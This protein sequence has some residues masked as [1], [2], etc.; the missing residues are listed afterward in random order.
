MIRGTKVLPALL[1]ASFATWSATPAAR[2]D[3][4]D[5]EVGGFIGLHVFND[6]NELG[7]WDRADADSLRNSFTVGLRLAYALH[8]LVSVEGEAAFYPT[9]SRESDVDA[10]AFGYRI[11]GLVHFTKPE[12]RLRPFAVLGFGGMSTTRSDSNVIHQDTDGMFHGGLGLKYRVG[13]RWGV[14]LDGR[15][16]TPPSTANSGVTVDFEV[17]LGL[18]TTLGKSEKKAEPAPEQPKDSDG[19]GIY[20][21][22]DKCPDQKEDVD[23]YV[24]DDGCPDLDNDGDGIPD[25]KDECPNDAE[26]ANGVDDEDGCPETDEDGDGL[27]GSADECPTEPEDK[28]GFEDGNGCPDPDNDGDGIA[29]ADDQCPA[30]AETANGYQDADGCP[31]EVPATVAKFTGAIKGIKFKTNSA[32]IARTSYKVLSKA[33]KVLAEFPNLRVEIQGHTDDKGKD[34]KNLA[35]SQ[36]RAESVKKY[37]VK[38]GIDE[39]RLEA[40]GYGETAP[41]ADNTT[42]KG[43]AENRRVEFK[44]IGSN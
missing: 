13:D 18:Y 3:G 44:L 12:K 16:L 43:Q 31:D 29:D 19:D 32:V 36:K 39:S 21:D 33:A 10:I 23:Q 34:E 7:V 40:K 41:V 25:E 27:V 9:G 17:L 35:L 6:D 5:V 28:D 26:T 4:D 42:R 30:V 15:A 24:D 14:R 1:A 11:H 2:A 20:D 8:P 38:K 22:A 37:L